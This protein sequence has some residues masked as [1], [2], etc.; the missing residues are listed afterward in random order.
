MNKGR[1]GRDTAG[2]EG[3]GGDSRT[4]LLVRGSSSCPTP[5]LFWALSI[6]HLAEVRMTDEDS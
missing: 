6:P 1:D 3:T 5:S 2:K 4:V